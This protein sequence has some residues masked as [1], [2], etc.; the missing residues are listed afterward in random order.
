MPAVGRS[1]ALGLFGRPFVDLLHDRYKAVNKADCLWCPTDGKQA[2]AFL[3]SLDAKDWT[4]EKL[5]RC[6]QF[7]L[8]SLDHPATE[9]PHLWLARL[10]SYYEAPLDRFGRPDFE[11]R[12]R[13]E[14]KHTEKSAP[15]PAPRP[16]RSL[17][18]DPSVAAFVESLPSDPW[19]LVLDRLR[20]IVN[21]HSF[22]TWLKPTRFLGVD[23]KDVVVRVPNN[24]FGHVL[25]KWGDA[26]SAIFEELRFPFDGVSLEVVA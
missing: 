13:W 4:I 1:G 21:P 2:K 9:A 3:A 20:K 11:K 14:R 6:V 23:A 5:D 15:V 12:D 17:V 26:I 24:D 8:L 19:T 7:K 16:A 18:P 10:T 22:E 25:D